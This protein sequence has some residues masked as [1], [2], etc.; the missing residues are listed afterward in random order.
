[1]VSRYKPK[2]VSGCKRIQTVSSEM[3]Q[4]LFE[5]IRRSHLEEFSDAG[6]LFLLSF[7]AALTRR[8]ERHQNILCKRAFG[9]RSLDHTSTS[10][11]RDK[12]SENR[13]LMDLPGRTFHGNREEGQVYML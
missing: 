12:I 7:L 1:M 8:E 13:G 11:V 5:S 3:F 10:T 9:N 6:L 4:M 2:F